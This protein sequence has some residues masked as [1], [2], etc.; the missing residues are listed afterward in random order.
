[1]QYAHLPP[2][3]ANFLS[4][5][6]VSNNKSRQNSHNQSPANRKSS[7]SSQS[8]GRNSTDLTNSKKKYSK[9]KSSELKDTSEESEENASDIKSDKVRKLRKKYRYI[10]TPV[11][12]QP[13]NQVDTDSDDDDVG[14]MLKA[15]DVNSVNSIS[16]FKLCLLIL[17]ILQELCIAELTV[18]Q[19][20]KLVSPGSLPDL[21]QCLVSLEDHSDTHTDYE[22]QATKVVKLHLVRVVLLYTGIAASHQNGLH[23]FK[24]HRIVE[25]VLSCSS[26]LV[27]YQSTTEYSTKD[28]IEMF[29]KHKLDMALMSDSALGLLSCLTLVFNNL[30]FNPNFT[31][32]ALFLV[33]EFDDHKGFHMLERCVLLKDLLKT[34]VK[35]IA[36]LANI[37]EDDPVKVLSTFLN[38]L[39]LVRVN[40]VHS[41]KCVKR[42]HQKCSYH[43]YLDHHHD[44]LG[45]AA[46]SNSS[47]LESLTL[48][49]RRPSQSSQ[50]SL[51]SQH[52]HQ[53]VCLVSSCTQYLLDLL[54]KVN[55]KVIQLDLLQAVRSSGICCCM[56]LNT[57][58][59]RFVEGL[60]KF[61]PAVRAFCMETLN[62]I[63]LEQFSGKSFAVSEQ[64]QA[65]SCAFCSD[66]SCKETE[67]L[68]VDLG[69]TSASVEKAFD[70]GI[71]SSDLN[72][73]RMSA[74]FKF[75]KWR[76][77]SHLRA[78]LFSS[79]EGLAISVAKHL[80]VLAIKGNPFLKAELFFS[81]YLHA[82]DMSGRKGG[83]CLKS[84]DTQLTLSKTVQV[85]C[86][87]ALPFLLQA[88]CVTKVFLS[89]KGVG[90][91]CE[92]LEDD[93][94]RAPVLRVFEALV[95]LDEYQFR[96]KQKSL[97]SDCPCPYKGGRVID[98]F[99]QELSKRSFNNSE[100]Y[101]DESEVPIG[102]RVR[103]DSVVLSQ[104]SLP[105][106][107]DLWNT[108]A[109]LCLHSHVF[110]EQ[111]KDSQCL[112][113][114]ESL[115]VET[116]D[117]VVSPDLIGQLKSHGSIEAEDSGMEGEPVIITEDESQSCFTRRLALM[118]SLMTV[119]GSVARTMDV[120][121]SK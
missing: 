72:S 10:N 92:M 102:R 17:S 91:L 81:L 28:V 66:V 88:N 43:Q 79:N 26:T 57:I 63:I 95:V 25:Q 41:M 113:K 13:Q 23:I 33:E 59:E 106:L 104:F 20:G 27:S 103:K 85:H 118:E 38:T 48:T 101:Y 64:G 67:L 39:K 42:K 32:T 19:D 115:L 84:G 18:F 45:V 98:A 5:L 70:S 107:V 90:R 6:P 86:L 76:P 14:N 89:K 29:Q 116:L 80:I 4:T 100:T 96:D 61:S 1:M 78:L 36:G 22:T 114:T 24:G 16:G 56:N 62:R 37:L 30:P 34:H 9:R 99:I 7:N 97:Q 55:S 83:L 12:K 93:T 82:L 54:V 111:F 35:H 8:T 58:M 69:H 105:V 3:T 46:G 11:E 108:C 94:L 119:I 50:S 21:L 121:V 15:L 75:S 60:L 49:S 110:V 73:E 65:V 112:N 74:L 109:K 52:S 117:I 77:I 68:R 53:V 51:S 71:D 87:S 40:Y 120:D 44:I 2:I 31:K 47:D